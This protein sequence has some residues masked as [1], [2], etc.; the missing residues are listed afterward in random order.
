MGYDDPINSTYASTTEMYEKC[1]DE[2]LWRIKSSKE[3]VSPGRI[4]VMAATHNEDTVRF[5]LR[6]LGQ[7]FTIFI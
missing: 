7:L 2:C 1:M 5:V 4:K 3:S 6:R